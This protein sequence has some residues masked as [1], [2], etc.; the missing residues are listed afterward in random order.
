MVLRRFA[1]TYLG[2][3]GPSIAEAVASG[4]DVADAGALNRVL[5]AG[6]EAGLDE[7]TVVPG[8]WDLTCLEAIADV[9][10]NRAS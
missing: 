6:V 2:F 8:T 5:D 4:L 7:F 9:V 10:G 1:A 3:L